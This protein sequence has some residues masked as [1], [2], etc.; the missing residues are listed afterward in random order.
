MLKPTDKLELE[1]GGRYNLRTFDEADIAQYD[2][3]FIEAAL[4]WEATD[5]LELTASVTRSLKEPSAS[6][7]LVRDSTEYAA[8]II[9]TPNG[10][11]TVDLSGS[12]ERK[13]EIGG[14][15]IEF[16]NG[17]EAGVSYDVT[18]YLTMFGKISHDWSRETDTST[19]ETA[20]SANTGFK[21][22]MTTSFEG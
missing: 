1:L 17:V 22:G 9:W 6:S 21:V 7:A 20:K 19:G 18:N 2:N 12:H 16:E 5:Q 4:S 14:D 13:E 11:W 3:A 10:K 15:E 8:G